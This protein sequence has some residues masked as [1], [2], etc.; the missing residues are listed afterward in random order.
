MA[1]VD[2]A[3]EQWEAARLTA[4]DAGRRGAVRVLDEIQSYT[5][6]LGQL[7]DAGNS[8]ML[9]HYLDLLAGA[10]MLTGLQKFAGDVARSRRLSPKLQVLNAALVAAASGLTLDEARSDREYWGRLTESA[11]AYLANAAA[12]G[13]CELYCRHDRNREVDFVVHRKARDGHRGQ[14]WPRSRGS[15]G[16]VG[17]CRRVQAE[18]DCARGR[19]RDFCRRGYRGRHRGQKRRGGCRPIAPRV[20]MPALRVGGSMAVCCALDVVVR[21]L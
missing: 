13:E 20:S 4:R 7:Q 6:M 10:G 14:E 2:C 8:T 11:G 16:T 15:T 9:A 1:G 12:T 17:L 18:A 5:E 3:A 21:E 19:R